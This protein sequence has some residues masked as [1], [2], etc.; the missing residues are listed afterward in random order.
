MGRRVAQ[1][2]VGGRPGGH[3]AGGEGARKEAWGWVF[4]HVEGAVAEG[5]VIAA[6]RALRG[7]GCWQVARSAG[8]GRQPGGQGASESLC[9][10]RRRK[11]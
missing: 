3:R 11:P 4:K 1:G 5:A 8:R 2:G 10:V 9:E 7:W 6:G